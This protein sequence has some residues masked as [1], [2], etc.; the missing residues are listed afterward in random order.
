MPSLCSKAYTGGRNK[1]GMR[2]DR[3]DPSISK[4]RNAGNPPGA[5]GAAH[6]VLAAIAAILL[7]PVISLGGLF[8]LAYGVLAPLLQLFGMR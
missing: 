2:Y 1:G 3:H 6:P 4:Y 7:L 8:G 5:D